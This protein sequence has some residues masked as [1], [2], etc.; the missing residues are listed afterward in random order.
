VFWPILQILEQDHLKWFQWFE[1]ASKLIKM[2]L[3]SS[4]VQSN[5]EKPNSGIFPFSSHILR[6]ISSNL[7]LGTNLAS[8]WLEPFIQL[9]LTANKPHPCQSKAKK[10][11]RL[12]V[13]KSQ[14][15]HIWLMPFFSILTLAHFGLH[16]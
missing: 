11:K 10:N 7:D 5:G 15:P 12:K 16:H 13:R 6:A 1:I 14:N 8:K 2:T 3:E 4:Q 9:L